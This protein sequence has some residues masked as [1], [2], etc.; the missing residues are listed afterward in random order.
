M[1]YDLKE[2]SLV[3]ATYN[4]EESIGATLFELKDYKFYE[5]VI[6]DNNSNDKTVEIAKQFNVKIIN[7][8][9]KVGAMQS[10]KHLMMQ[11][12]NI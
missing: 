10:F 9:N 12:E 4:E 3:I 11:E 8:N 1:K 7:Q 5:I 2:V 6:V